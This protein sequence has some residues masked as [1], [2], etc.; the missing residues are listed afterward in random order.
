[1]PPGLER[2]L[3]Q[4]QL[5]LPEV[6]DQLSIRFIGEPYRFKLSYVLK[7]LE[8]TRDRNQ[9]QAQFSVFSHALPAQGLQ[10]Q[11]YYP[12]A[13]AFLDELL[14]IKENLQV[15]DI[16]CRELEQLISQVEIFGFHLTQL[17]V[18]QESSCHSDTLT[19]VAEYLQ[20]LPQSYDEMS[21]AERITW[22]VAELQTRRPLIPAELP[23][24]ER[25][26]EIIQTF[27]MIRRLQEEFGPN[28]CR[29]YIIS[30][31]HEASDLLEVLLFAKESGLYDPT[32]ATGS[33]HVIPLFETVDDLQRAPEVM[34]QLFE[35]GLY[36]NYLIDP[37]LT[38][39]RAEDHDSEQDLPIALQEIMLGY[40]DSNKDSGFLSSNWEIYKA[41]QS[42]QQMAEPYGIAL[43][44]FH[45][46]GGSVGRGGGPAYEAI[47]AQPGHSVN[48]RIKITEQGEVV[49]S[50]YSL[51][52][53]A[54]YNLETISTAVI[55]SSLLRSTIDGI[56]PWHEIMEDLAAR[57]RK[58]YRSLIYEE[59]DLV[60]F[61][62]EVTPIHEISQLQ[63]AARPSRRRPDNQR[64]LDGLRA[65]PWVFGWT[66]SRFCYQPGLEWA[67]PCKIF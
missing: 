25:A 47:L 20:I 13:T 39:A 31:S 16:G 61:F 55:Q 46:R 12:S 2:S 18:R 56:E 30:M 63:H 3:G 22:L 9:Q 44:I 57:S 26:Q 17:D 7:R 35:L 4:D 53:L 21:E 19:E 51:P 34:T 64:S 40:S 48:G 37:Q 15:T 65:I 43:R 60:D 33:L 45:G 28:I 5:Q 24:S 29:T 32:T 42:L 62:Y 66:Q 58:R 27:R 14:L 36:R 59:A 8:N 1:M 38:T 11:S 54:L 49:A 67:R 6:Y 23:F 10:E 41:Q 50:K 52:E